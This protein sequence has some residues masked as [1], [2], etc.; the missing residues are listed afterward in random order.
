[1]TRITIYD[2]T[3]PL[4]DEMLGRSYGLAQE[5]LS[6]AGSQVQKNARKAMKRYTHHWSHKINKNG[7]RWIFEDKSSIYEL[8]ARIS[9]KSGSASS[10]KSMSSLISSYLAPHSLT[11]T[12]GGAHPNFR[13]R[14]FKDGMINGTMSTVKGV[15]TKGR[16]ILHKLNTGEVSDE[17]PYSK[18]SSSFEHPFEN[19]DRKYKARPFMDIAWMESQ[20][21]INDKL[22]KRYENSFYRVMN[23]VKVK[24]VK[25]TA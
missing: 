9:H 11:V 4:L 2:N 17:H 21:V 19:K 8:G 23:D 13:P 25:R 15:G 22:K 14:K 3:I 6:V 18:V 10:P 5:S 7:K 16:A 24:T 12:V 1:M 20:G